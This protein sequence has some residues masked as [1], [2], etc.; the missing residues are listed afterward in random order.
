MTGALSSIQAPVPSAADRS[1]GASTNIGLWV[2]GPR[3]VYVAGQYGSL[4]RY[5]GTG[6]VGIFD[7]RYAHG[8]TAIH[9]NAASG[10]V[11]AVTEAGS[12][13][14]SATLL[15]GSGPTGCFGSPTGGPSVW[16]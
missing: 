10:C 15:R 8:I 9:G 12:T 6:W 3:E 4:V 5:D 7:Q 14:N 2:R 1:N 11:L 16:P 13:N